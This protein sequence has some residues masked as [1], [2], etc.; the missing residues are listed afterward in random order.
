MKPQVIYRSEL[1]TV[2]VCDEPTKGHTYR[3]K[4]NQSDTYPFGKRVRTF[5]GETAWSDAER[6]AYDHDRQSVGCTA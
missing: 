3:V 2:T 6:Y 5:T 1:I 4:V